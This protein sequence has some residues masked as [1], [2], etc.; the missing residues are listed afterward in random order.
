LSDEDRKEISYEFQ[1]A[2]NEV[3]CYKLI[4]AADQKGVKTVLLAG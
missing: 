4:E 3:L 2:V 1:S